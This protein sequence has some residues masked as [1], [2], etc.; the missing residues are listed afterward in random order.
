L[1]VDCIPKYLLDS[2]FRHIAEV[3]KFVALRAAQLAG[4]RARLKQ[5]EEEWL[6]P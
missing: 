5:L 4:A 6:K 2:Y 3:E 1:E